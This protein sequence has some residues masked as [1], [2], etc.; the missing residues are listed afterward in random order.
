MKRGVHHDPDH[1]TTYYH[2]NRN[3][4]LIMT[5]TE[6]IVVAILKANGWP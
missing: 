5:T 2:C 6:M 1:L 3:P 4:S